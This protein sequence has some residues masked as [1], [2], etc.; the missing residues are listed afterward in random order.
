MGN[1]AFR[2]S[3]P[4]RSICPLTGGRARGVLATGQTFGEEGKLPGES[5]ILPYALYGGILKM[6]LRE[7]GAA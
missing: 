5:W 4:P 1:G 6:T 7:D 3:T 2:K